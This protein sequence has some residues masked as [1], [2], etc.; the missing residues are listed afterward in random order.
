MVFNS[1]EF[2]IFFVI[3][4]FLYWIVG[5]SS[6][7]I[8]NIILL[9]GGYTFYGW[10]DWRLLSYL[11]ASSTITFYLG[12]YIEK[13]SNEKYKQWLLYLG[14]AQGIGGLAF[15]KYFNFFIN[16]YLFPRFKILN[17]LLTHKSFWIK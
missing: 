6:L 5:K 10:S 9:L 2:L 12:I 8:Q 4:F 1:F 3:I 13:T 15:F 16:S 11:I 14:L 17:I 7:K